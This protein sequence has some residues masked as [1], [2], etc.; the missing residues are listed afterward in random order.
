MHTPAQALVAQRSYLTKTKAEW[1]RL[2]EAVNRRSDLA[3]FQWG[4]LAAFALDFK[5]DLILE[6]GRG[7]GNSTALFLELLTQLPGC[8][9]I[10]LCRANTWELETKARLKFKPASWFARGDIR[11]CEITE[12]RIDFSPYQRVFLFWDAH[13]FEV[14]EWVLGRVM[15]RLALR[16]HIVAMHDLSDLRFN[17]VPPRYTGPLWKGEVG[18]HDFHLGTIYSR[19]PQAI[20]ALDFCTR[21]RIPLN[22]AEASLTR[23]APAEVSQCEPLGDLF[24]QQAHW[25]WF[26]LN[27]SDAPHTFPLVPEDASK[28]TL[29]PSVE[30]RIA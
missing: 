30:R 15:P 16:Q 8:D 9:F 6:L 4:Q 22:S 5:P 3:P 24:A 17:G 7:V 14:A 11:V 21:N 23:M 25:Y 19:V 20:S 27:Q 10:S 26:S 2:I 1:G 12:Q 13:G 18:E 28:A 29:F